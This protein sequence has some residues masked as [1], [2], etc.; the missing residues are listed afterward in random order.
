M[1]KFLEIL[2]SKIEIKTEGEIKFLPRGLLTIV[3]KK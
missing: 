2:N 1:K 3:Q